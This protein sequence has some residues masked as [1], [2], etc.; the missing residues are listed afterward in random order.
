MK[1]LKTALIVPFL[2]TI[3][4]C[5]KREPLP[6]D[7]RTYP[8]V[9]EEALKGVVR[10]GFDSP[11]PT[12]DQLDRRVRN[13]KIIKEMGLPVLESLPVVEDEKAVKFRTAEDVAKRC[14]ATTI[15][16]VQGE[17]PDQKL[18]KELI[19]R[20]SAAEYCACLASSCHGS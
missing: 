10:T 13:N 6:T 4:S 20:Y 17:E 16:A 2:V 9:K 15:C 19:E 11:S 7:I 8:T 1:H 18:T 5:S 14:V 12:Q 3:A